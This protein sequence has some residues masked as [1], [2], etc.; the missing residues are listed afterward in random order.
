MALHFEGKPTVHSFHS[1]VECNME[2][3][4]QLNCNLLLRVR[5][6]NITDRLMQNVAPRQEL[7]LQH[8]L[9]Y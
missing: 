6:T 2:G 1:S 7:E 3:E 5:I 9:F 4:S 8:L